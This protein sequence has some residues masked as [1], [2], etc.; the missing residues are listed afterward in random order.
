[1]KKFL[2]TIVLC[3]T[4]TTTMSVASVWAEDGITVNY[5]GNAISFDTPPFLENGITMVPYHT[6]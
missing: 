5:E 2:A 4:L 1:M 3:I 6:G